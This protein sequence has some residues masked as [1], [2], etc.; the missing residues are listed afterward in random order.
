MRTARPTGLRANRQEVF[1][2]EVDCKFAKLTKLSF[3]GGL[4]YFD[5][6]RCDKSTFVIRHNTGGAMELDDREAGRL[7]REN[8]T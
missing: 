7:R 4:M 1:F 2:V 6:P 3:F 5:L 8:C